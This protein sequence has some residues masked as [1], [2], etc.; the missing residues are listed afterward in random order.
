[1]HFVLQGIRL[2]YMLAYCI[3]FDLLT[4]TGNSYSVPNLIV[5]SAKVNVVNIGGN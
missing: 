1:M 2:S 5:I 4:C 3:S